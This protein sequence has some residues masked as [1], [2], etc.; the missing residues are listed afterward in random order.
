MPMPATL[1]SAAPRD[2]PDRHGFVLPAVLLAIVILTI[3]TTAGFFSV[4][5]EARIGASGERAAKALY[6]A[7]QGLTEV[8]GRWSNA[9]AA[10]MPVW[11]TT[12]FADTTSSGIWTV[13]LTRGNERIFYLDA[14]GTVTDGGALYAGAQRRI[15]MAARMSLPRLDPRAAVTTTVNVS[16]QGQ[17]EVHGED[18]IPPGWGGVCSGTLANRGGVLMQDTTTLSNSGASQLTGAPPLLED[19]TLG[20]HTFTQFGDMAWPELV[21]LA[22]KVY[23]GGSLARFGAQLDAIGGCDYGHTQNWGDPEN[24]GAPCGGYFPVVYIAGDA[25]LQSGT[26]GQGILLVEGD[27]VVRGDVLFHG[28]V[29]AQGAYDAEGTDNRIYGAVMANNVDIEQTGTLGRSGVDYSSCAVERA[30][31]NAKELDRA[32]PLSQRGWVDLSALPAR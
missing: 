6:L 25:T 12:Q 9:S 28:L 18:R 8:L 24:P 15:G 14:T 30:L 11:G 4:Q 10:A 23:G 3:V 2:R 32:R 16:V 20:Q 29:I 1:A 27:L 5:Q 21:S 19:P 7:E 26:R 17:A 13:T 31:L 22:S